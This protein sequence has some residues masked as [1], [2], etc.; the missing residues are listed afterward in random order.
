MVLL[1]FTGIVMFETFNE[2]EIEDYQHA[3]HKREF[4][5][6]HNLQEDEVCQEDIEQVEMNGWSVTVDGSPYCLH[7]GLEICESFD[8][9]TG[10]KFCGS[11]RN[12]LR[13][14]GQ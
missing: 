14:T 2:D 6:L 4:A 12:S 10:R 9:L 13:G 3:Q 7:C 8:E 1:E 11:C 5:V